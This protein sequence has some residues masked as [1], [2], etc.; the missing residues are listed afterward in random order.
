MSLKGPTPEDER[1][2]HA[3]INQIG[4]Q[5]FILTTLAL[6]LFGVLTTIMVP[7][8]QAATDIG[9]PFAVSALLSILL[10]A[11]Y[12]WSHTLKN[13]MRIFTSYLVETGKSQWEQDWL[14]FRHKPYRAHTIGQTHIFLLLNFLGLIIPYLL[15]IIYRLPIHPLIGPLAAFL[16]FLITELLIYHMGYH[17]LLDDEKK[18]DKRWKELNSK[19]DK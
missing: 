17:K 14:E 3:E 16:A 12:F 5:R 6:T 15:A 11:I 9:F 7:K 19:S 4:N 18:I 1:K 8:P 13:T 10:F 2:L